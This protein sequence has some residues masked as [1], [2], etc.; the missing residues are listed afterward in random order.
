MEYIPT[1]TYFILIDSTLEGNFKPNK[2]IRQRDP[3]SRIFSLFAKNLGRYLTYVKNIAKSSLGIQPVWKAQKMSYLMFSNDYIIFSRTI[4]KATRIRKEILESYEKGLGMNRLLD[5]LK[6]NINIQEMV[7]K[8]SRHN[9]TWN[10]ELLSQ[11]IPTNNVRQITFIR[12]SML[13]I[14]DRKAWKFT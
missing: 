7:C 12:M 5:M 8:Y 14:M 2:G 10:I 3:L 9:K 6:E 13:D 11:V 4:K 1:P